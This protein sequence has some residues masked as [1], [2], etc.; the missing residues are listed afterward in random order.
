MGQTLTQKIIAQHAGVESVTPGQLV[1]VGV[2]LVYANDVTATLAFDRLEHL[3]LEG[4]FDPS[5]IF[6][7]PIHFS[8]NVDRRS[9]AQV[10]AAR[11]YARRYG[12]AFPE[13]GKMGI[14][15]VYLCQEG[16]IAPGD[17]IVGGDSHATTPGALGA[18]STGMG[19]TDIAAVLYEGKTWLRVPETIKVELHGRPGRFIGGKDIILTIIGRTGVSGALYKALEFTG[20]G[21]A[22]LG[23][24]DRMTLCN[25]AVEAGAKNAIIAVDAVTA[26]YLAD[27]IAAPIQRSQSDADAPYSARIEID[28][29]ALE[30]VVA[31]PHS[32][33]NV[34][35]VNEV[36]GVHVDQVVIGSCTNGKLADLAGAAYIMRGRKVAPHVRCIV[37]PAT[38][39]IYLQALREGFIAD[40][41]AA[42]CFVSSSTCG[43][44]AGF[45]LGV[46]D[47]GEVCVSTT[48]RN[49]RG[50]MGHVD[51]EIYLAGPCVAAASA[52]A[53]QICDP[54]ELL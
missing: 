30:P 4:V 25:M 49:F 1:R 10:S 40:L 51:S 11:R 3:G 32:P 34:V 48:P 39:E 8:P 53:G 20:D 9:A 33:G 2:D 37:I 52:V 14:D 41:I 36:R 50:R 15:N 47:R 29:P 19:S 21:M 44:C 43:P 7:S 23:M 13:A 18:F 31:K 27:R 17:V 28:L 38:Q 12:I 46:L 22:R 54:R 6:I 35:P 42:G 45:Q 26:Q 5:R 24:D 16:Y